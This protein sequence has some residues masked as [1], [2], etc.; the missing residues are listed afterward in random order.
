MKILAI[1]DTH[2]QHRKLELPVADLLV[3]SG[4][5][6]LEGEREVIEDFVLWLAGLDIEHKVFIA[7]NHDSYAENNHR[8]LKSLA[9]D[10]GIH[11][12]RDSGVSIEGVNVWGSPYTPRFMQW[13]FM[14]DPGPD[15]FKCWQQIPPQTDIL[16]THGPPFGTLDELY[17]PAGRLV[18]AG[19]RELLLAVR[20]I[21]PALHIF[22]HIHECH[23]S[24]AAPSTLFVNASS[25]DEHYRLC[26]APR[27]LDYSGNAVVTEQ[28]HTVAAVRTGIESQEAASASSVDVAAELQER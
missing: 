18:R 17:D 10:A 13:S 22:G 27:L 3:H 4:D 16:V 25:M 15:M 14:H 6:T 2:G 9:T 28:A 7:G 5:I 21:Q 19:C 8:E 24:F 20:K 26:H 23:G 11:Y 12:L 1:S